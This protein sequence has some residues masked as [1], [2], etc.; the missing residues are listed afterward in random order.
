MCSPSSSH[1]CVL[2]SDVC[3]GIDDCIDASDENDCRINPSVTTSTT[4]SP[5]MPL[6]GQIMA[7]VKTDK[8]GNYTKHILN[9][10]DKFHKK[11]N[12][13]N[14]EN[15]TPYCAVINEHIDCTDTGFLTKILR[16]DC[17]RLCGEDMDDLNVDIPHPEKLIAILQQLQGQEIFDSNLVDP[18]KNYVI[19]VVDDDPEDGV[20]GIYP[21]P[22][23]GDDI[24]PVVGEYIDRNII[25]DSAPTNLET[26]NLPGGHISDASFGHLIQ[27]LESTK[28][29]QNGLPSGSSEVT[30]IGNQLGVILTAHDGAKT[31]GRPEGGNNV[32]IT[33]YKNKAVD[34]TAPDS[35][36]GIIY[37]TDK[38]PKQNI[39]HTLFTGTDNNLQKTENGVHSSTNGILPTGNSDR[40]PTSSNTENIY[41]PNQTTISG[42]AG[43]GSKN[44]NAPTIGTPTNHQNNFGH[45]PVSTGN[46]DI[47]GS[48]RIVDSQA[49][50]GQSSIITGNPQQSRGNQ[51]TGTSISQTG[52]YPSTTSPTNDQYT[53]TTGN[54]HQSTGALNNY[55]NNN[56]T[57]G[58]P[59]D[60]AGNSEPNFE[61][62]GNSEIFTDGSGPDTGRPALNQNFQYPT[63][64]TG[65]TTG[66]HGTQTGLKTG[67]YSA[68][69]SDNPLIPDDVRN[70][71]YRPT[72]EPA[73][74]NIPNGDYKSTPGKSAETESHQNE[75]R[76]N[77]QRNLEGQ[78]SQSDRNINENSYLDDNLDG[79]N[80]LFVNTG[81]MPS[82]TGADEKYQT[83]SE[84]GR[85]G[86]P[87]V[88][89]TGNPNYDAT[90]GILPESS[91]PTQT[92]ISG[93]K[94]ENVPTVGSFQT[95]E[96]TVVDEIGQSGVQT[97]NYPTVD[98][99][100]SDTVHN[101]RFGPTV[102][103][104]LS[105]KPT[106]NNMD[107]L[108]S[109]DG[110][111]SM[112]IIG[113]PGTNPS[114]ISHQD[115]FSAS[116]VAYPAK[117]HPQNQHVNPISHANPTGH[118]PTYPTNTDNSMLSENSGIKNLID[119][120][121]PAQNPPKENINREIYRPENKF[122]PTLGPTDNSNIM[123]YTRHPDYKNPSTGFNPRQP[124]V[125]NVNNIM[126]TMYTN[127]QNEYNSD[128]SPA[129]PK[130]E[131]LTNQNADIDSTNQMSDTDFFSLIGTIE[132]DPY[133]PYLK[134]GQTNIGSSA[135]HPETTGKPGTKN[136]G[137]TGQISGQI[138][139]ISAQNPTYSTFPIKPNSLH[140]N[141]RPNI[142]P[143]S[144]S[145]GSGKIK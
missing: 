133:R 8:N 42:V 135:N 85:H 9:I 73:L 55:Y 4:K 87:T 54:R 137:P 109:P 79:S 129:P 140:S 126:P 47:P 15:L 120:A 108:H 40:G 27:Q 32:I 103:S 37:G 112:D 39:I 17:P 99:E 5:S 11:K 78:F 116:T 88:L 3:N 74:T 114:T 110:T 57:G 20:E 125:E 106:G 31:P 111:T 102:T 122:G 90:T 59:I 143:G 6:T 10:L 61:Y 7:D 23:T 84:N 29:V 118:N 134:P 52:N 33:P 123:S 24:Y 2:H 81:S 26:A 124:T 48:H 34:N 86:I 53:V 22:K 121:Y 49:K 72:T 130:D 68:D 67:T 144:I 128:L 50:Y 89:P 142:S 64:G 45:T 131:K 14:N 16:K 117:I 98:S 44:D 75:I 91:H 18:S 62:F 60:S 28:P 56:P 127:T 65:D 58:N 46:R 92:G 77:E 101:Y 41:F 139:P 104:D 93:P 1:H 76:L 35:N 94:S 12:V 51:N 70:H 145:P 30:Q 25:L 107:N 82:S 95:G 113:N 19:F 38:T 83:N 97:G 71:R 138:G 36:Y 13:K 43:T 132:L 105:H 69:D 66:L 96:P 119:N 100:K 21:E 63:H 115:S 136:A 141:S 80:Y